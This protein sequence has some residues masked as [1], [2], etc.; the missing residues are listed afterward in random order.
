MTIIWMLSRRS[1]RPKC[2]SQTAAV[3]HTPPPMLWM[4]KRLP[5]RSA[6]LAIPG[7]AT[8]SSDSRLVKLAMILSSLPP[9][10]AASAVVAPP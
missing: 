1:S 3:F 10:A 8:R 2:S 7:R 5:R 6:A 4:P 9:A